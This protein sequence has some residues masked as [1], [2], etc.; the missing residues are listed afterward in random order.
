MV[1]LAEEAAARTQ[2][3]RIQLALAAARVAVTVMQSTS[4][5]NPGKAAAAAVAHAQTKS[6][7]LAVT[8]APVASC[9][10]QTRFDS[11]AETS[12]PV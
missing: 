3:A 11:E 10:Y 5:G 8:E 2:E 4:G 6:E 1:V 7:L 9:S 12:A